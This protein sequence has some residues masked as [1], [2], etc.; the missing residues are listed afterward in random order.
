MKGQLYLVR[1]LARGLR[2]GARE[3]KKI[4]GDPALSPF[5]EGKERERK[6]ERMGEKME[7]VYGEG[8]MTNIPWRICMHLEYRYRILC[9]KNHSTKTLHSVVENLQT[10]QCQ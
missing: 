2:K 5:C 1:L 8:Y 7:I 6:K 3:A 4:K 10:W 9:W